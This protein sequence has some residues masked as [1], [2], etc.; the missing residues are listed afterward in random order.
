MNKN[1]LENTEWSSTAAENKVLNKMECR[2]GEKHV[3]TDADFCARTCVD[4]SGCDKKVGAVCDGLAFEVAKDGKLSNTR[5]C[6][7]DSD[8]SA[9]TPATIEP[10]MSGPKR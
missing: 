4:D 3:R 5:Y 8:V 9:K 10:S 2:S 6:T 7:S 1:T